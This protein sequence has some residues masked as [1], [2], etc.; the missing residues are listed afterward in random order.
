MVVREQGRDIP[1]TEAVGYRVRRG[2]SVD[3][4]TM[5]ESSRLRKYGTTSTGLITDGEMA[6]IRLNKDNVVEA[7]IFR[8][9]SIDYGSKRLLLLSPD[10]ASC[11]IRY[12]GGMI[13]VSAQGNGEVSLLAGSSAKVILNGRVVAPVRNEGML[14]FKA[15]SQEGLKLTKPVFST[16]P[17]D[18]GRAIGIP[19][20]L[21]YRDAV[22]IK[23]KTSSPSDATIE[24]RKEEDKRWIRTVNPEFSTDHRFVIR[25]LEDGKTYNLRIVCYGE[26][27]SPGRLDAPY[28]HIDP[29][30]NQGR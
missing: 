1:D 22:V 11:Y 9:T 19:R 23:W 8:G 3:I 6:Y 5:A 27:G 2:E 30:K 20:P 4:L 15:G 12:T 16:T 7:G 29:Q 26:D 25:R 13:E 17:E 21:A 18:L 24:Y 28:T 14:K 10:I